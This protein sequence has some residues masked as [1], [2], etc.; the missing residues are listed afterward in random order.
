MQLLE[1][2]QAGELDLDISGLAF[3]PSGRR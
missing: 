1:V 3:A 2:R